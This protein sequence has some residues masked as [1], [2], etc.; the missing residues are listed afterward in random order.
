MI[1]NGSGI[2]PMRALIQERHYQKH[3]MGY[4]VG[5]SELFFGIRRRDLDFLYQDEFM[6]YKQSGTLSALYLACSREQ[7]HKIYVQHMV[8][9][10]AE[11]V[12]KLLQRGGHIYICGGSSM[13]AEVEQVLKA[14]ASRQVGADGVEDF[15]SKLAKD[16][17]YV[18]EA[19]D[20]NHVMNSN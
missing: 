2:G 1:A 12:W 14:I 9:K 5:P 3:T 15:M 7:M 11:H 16:G 19:F 20:A 6:K 18:Q 13:R 8:A 17:R 4:L 10:H